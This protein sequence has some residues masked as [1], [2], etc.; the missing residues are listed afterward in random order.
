MK[1]IIKKSPSPTP[2]NIK[3]SVSTLTPTQQLQ[4]DKIME[5]NFYDLYVMKH[6]YMVM[7]WMEANDWHNNGTPDDEIIVYIESNFSQ[8]AWNAIKFNCI[9]DYECPTDEQGDLPKL[10]NY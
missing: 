6:T 8:W 1:F 7:G 10:V 9:N 3:L 4:K 2:E 5:S